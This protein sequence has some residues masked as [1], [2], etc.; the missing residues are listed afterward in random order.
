MWTTDQYLLFHST[1]F[2]LRVSPASSMY[3]IA[4]TVESYL[5][6]LAFAL[7]CHRCSGHMSDWLAHMSQSRAGWDRPSKASLQ[8]ACQSILDLLFSKTIWLGGMRYGPTF[9]RVSQHLVIPRDHWP[10]ECPPEAQIIRYIVRSLYSI[11]LW[12][13]ME[14]CLKTFSSWG[15]YCVFLGKETSNQIWSGNLIFY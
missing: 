11:L 15:F 3:W 10:S 1:D 4:E 14:S 12:S 8:Y 13:G 5:C 7:Y 6:I 9:T 2:S